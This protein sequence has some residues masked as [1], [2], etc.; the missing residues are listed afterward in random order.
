MSE[1]ALSDA[2]TQID[3]FLSCRTIFKSQVSLSTTWVSE[4]KQVLGLSW[5]HFPAELS[6]WSA[7]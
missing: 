5:K 6:L 2:I 7:Q 1:S 3:L 4:M